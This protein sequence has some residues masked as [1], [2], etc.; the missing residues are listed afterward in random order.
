MARLTPPACR[1]ARAL[2]GWSMRDLKDKAGVALA[3]VQ[4]IEAGGD[5]RASTGDKIMDAFAEH[6]VDI[7]NGDAPG[8]RMK[9]GWTAPAGPAAD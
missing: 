7:L 2:L 5:F 9:P 1:A 4:A 6:G 8:A 3:T